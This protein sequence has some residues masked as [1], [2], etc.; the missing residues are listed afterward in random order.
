MRLIY[1]TQFS[2]TLLLFNYSTCIKYTLPE[3]VSDEEYI[4]HNIS[5]FPAV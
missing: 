3:R 4:K 5:R 2:F 1:L